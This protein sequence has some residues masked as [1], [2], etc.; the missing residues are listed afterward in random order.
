MSC[1]DTLVKKVSDFRLNM[2]DILIMSSGITV[3]KITDGVGLWRRVSASSSAH[4][5]TLF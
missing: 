2:L 1:E 5:I 3:L 4:D